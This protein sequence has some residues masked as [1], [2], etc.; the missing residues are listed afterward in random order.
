MT[1]YTGHAF[2]LGQAFCVADLVSVHRESAT[3]APLA[4]DDV[5]LVLRQL[6]TRSC[7]PEPQVALHAP[8]VSDTHL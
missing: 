2:S 3:I 5:S 1:L 7:V 6:T 4:S 8:Y